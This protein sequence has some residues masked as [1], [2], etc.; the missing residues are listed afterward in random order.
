MFTN[1]NINTDE[2]RDK[3]S[4]LD[5]FCH[6]QGIT[7]E[8]VIVG[9]SAMNL[10]LAKENIVFRGTHDID[11]AGLDT[12][13]HDKLYQYLPKLGIEPVDGVLLP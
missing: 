2:I 1:E 6:E 11:I 3:L 8:F 10:L 5:K 12:T 9:G 4:L 13:N 7:A